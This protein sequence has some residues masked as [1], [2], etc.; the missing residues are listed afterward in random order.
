MYMDEDGFLWHR[1][2][3]VRI[4]LKMWNH[5]CAY[6]E[7]EGIFPSLCDLM[8]RWIKSNSMLRPQAELWMLYAIGH[9]EQAY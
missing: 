7:M 2:L 5:I 4:A 8:A 6:M 1:S 9:H 3:R